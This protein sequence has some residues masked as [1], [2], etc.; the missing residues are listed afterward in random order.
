MNTRVILRADGGQ[1]IGLGHIRR[2]MVL[3]RLFRVSGATVA[4]AVSNEMAKY[5]VDHGVVSAEILPQSGDWGAH[6]H[7]VTDINWSGNARVATH[8]VARLAKGAA[9]VTVIDSMPP[10]HFMSEPGGAPDLLITPY[11]NAANF[12]PETAAGKWLA[13][14]DYV[15]IDPDLPAQPSQAHQRPMRVLLSCGGADPEGLSIRAL[16]ALLRANVPVDIAVGP[17]FSPAL[18]QELEVAA[19]RAPQGQ[20]T[21]HH[22]PDGLGPLLATASLV[23]GRVGLLRYE[24]ASLALAGIYLQFGRAY[25][26]YLQAFAASGAGEVFFA[27]DD[28]GEA[29]FIQRLANLAPDDFQC[30]RKA[31]TLVDGKGAEPVV[32]AVLNLKKAAP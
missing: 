25:R 23:V 4:F 24:A 12:R 20:V 18:R 32:Q 15:V 27:E 30:N 10:D 26:E 11:L 31:R 6:N 3:A 9:S 1:Q 22:N 13:G 14:G 19:A 28:E 21:L 5:L 8:E 2:A 17:L 29:A 7:V 16:T